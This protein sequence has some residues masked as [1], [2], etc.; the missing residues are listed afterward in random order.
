MI[1][2]VLIS[3]LLIGAAGV[4]QEPE[5]V[6][7]FGTTVVIPSGLK[8]VIYH[9]SHFTKKL[10]NLEKEKPQGTYLHLVAEYSIAGL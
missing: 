1:G 5:P 9:I 10:P 3:G 4:A 7:V 2:A 6:Y 8:G